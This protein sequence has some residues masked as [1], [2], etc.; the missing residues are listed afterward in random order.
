MS[1]TVSSAVGFSQLDVLVSPGSMKSVNLLL[2]RLELGRD[3]LELC[4]L[5][6][7]CLHSAFGCLCTFLLLL[8]LAL[9]LQVSQQ[10][11]ESC[12]NTW[13]GT[14]DHGYT[15]CYIM[16]LESITASTII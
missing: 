14:G 7:Q 1:L 15:L 4:V 5:L 2:G 9:D 10:H 16:V 6:L 11:N 13:Y 3:P 12:H 8:Q